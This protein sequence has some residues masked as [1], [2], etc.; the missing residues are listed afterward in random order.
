LAEEIEM[1]IKDH[2]KGKLAAAP[3]EAEA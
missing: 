3:V 2:L 1:K